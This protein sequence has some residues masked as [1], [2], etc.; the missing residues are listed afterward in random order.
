MDQHLVVLILV[1]SIALALT[2]LLLFCHCPSFRITFT[3]WMAIGGLKADVTRTREG[4]LSMVGSCH[5]P[6]NHLN[7]YSTYFYNEL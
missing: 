4:N 5:P 6:F 1:V 2:R 3:F 7:R